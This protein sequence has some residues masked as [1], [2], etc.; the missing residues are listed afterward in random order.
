MSNYSFKGYIP[1]CIVRL[2][3]L[4]LTLRIVLFVAYNRE[5]TKRISKFYEIQSSFVKGRPG[6]G[7]L[8]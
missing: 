1:V 8:S 2:L 4:S 3:Y 7:W 5:S 6:V